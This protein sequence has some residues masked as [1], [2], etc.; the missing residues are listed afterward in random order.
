MVEMPALRLLVA[1]QLAI[2]RRGTRN[3]TA[4]G[5]DWD[6]MVDTPALPPCIAPLQCRAGPRAAPSTTHCEGLAPLH[7]RDILAACKHN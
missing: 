1:L 3:A 6:A 2:I 4:T 5:S 7:L